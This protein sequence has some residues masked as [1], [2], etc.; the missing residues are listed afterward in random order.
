M[1]CVNIWSFRGKSAAWGHASMQIDRTY[2]SWWPERPG[3]VPSHIHQD[4]YASN[5]FRN[6]TFAEDV[7]AE[8]QKPDHQIFIEGLDENRIKDWWQ[9]FGLNRDGVKY[10]GPLL[11][12]DTLKMNCSTV[13][14]TALRKGGGDTYS[15]WV[16]SWNLVWKPSDVLAYALSIQ[17]GLANKDKTV[18]DPLKNYKG[19]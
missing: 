6:R 17:K 19:F 1:L 16:K 13:V 15:S 3:L 12:W 8:K 5:P 10:Q 7:K 18:E 2:I 9:S 11:P 4:I 14:S